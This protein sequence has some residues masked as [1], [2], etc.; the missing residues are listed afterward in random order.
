MS[1]R[2]L[3]SRTDIGFNVD[4]MY[5]KTSQEIPDDFLD[6]LQ[7]ERHAKTAVRA[8]EYD[9]VCSVPTFVVDLWMRQGF[10]YYKESARAV[11]RRLREQGLEAFITTPKN[12]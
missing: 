9:R 10:D 11:V 12:V 4:G 3:T 2:L 8:G 7:S 1:Q 5:L 6:T